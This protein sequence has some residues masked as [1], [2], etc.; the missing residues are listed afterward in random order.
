M[1][2][3]ACASALA[4]DRGAARHCQSFDQR[5]HTQMGRR[6]RNPVIAP[7]PVLALHHLK[8]DAQNNW[9]LMITEARLRT[10]SMAQAASFAE[11]DVAHLIVG[12][13]LPDIALDQYRALVEHGHHLRHT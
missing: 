2:S 13:D 1:W 4:A 5:S 12:Q 3:C 8:A 11:I 10:S 9:D 6:P 7:V